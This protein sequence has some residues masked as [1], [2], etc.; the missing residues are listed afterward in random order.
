MSN[1][2]WNETSGFFGDFYMRGD[3]SVEGF[4][5]NRKLTLY[6]RTNTEVDGVV[7]L[8]D[9]KV[10]S[11]LLDVPC[12]YGRHSISLAKLGFDI[13]GFD[14]NKDHLVAA[15]SKA[16]QEKV[17]M[18]FEQGNMLNLSYSGEFDAVINM[19]YS[20]GF[21]DSD[22]ENLQVLRNFRRALKPKGKFLMHTD[23]NIPRIVNGTYKTNEIRSLDTGGILRIKEEFD[24]IKKRING[25]WLIE[26][27]NQCVERS[28]SVRVYE[29][30]EFRRMCLSVG[31]SNCDLFGGWDGT[32]YSEGESEEIIFVAE[33][34]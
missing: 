33:N 14:L 2:W 9:L 4:L 17:N 27:N 18:R 6:E 3:D 23:V 5:A 30:E 11:R 8:L 7:Q 21:F 12:G 29:A 15:R 20:F 34:F 13:V 32:A 28:Y 22:E 1:S 19:F 24:S 26:H 31:F 16:Q 25:T 10:T